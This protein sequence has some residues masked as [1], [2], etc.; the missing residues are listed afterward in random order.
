MTNS[1]KTA[2]LAGILGLVLAAAAPAQPATQR[3]QAVR[4]DQ[5][6]VTELDAH[7]SALIYWA[8]EPDGWHVVTTVDAVIAQDGKPEKHAVVRF[9]SLL[10]P[11]QS[12][13]ISVP[14]ALGERQRALRISRLGDQI[15]VAQVP[16]APV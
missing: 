7:T 16:G 15:K 9:S 13:L 4:E 12:Q 2:G 8:S 14:S 1:I 10:L 5:A 11:G 6:V 3:D